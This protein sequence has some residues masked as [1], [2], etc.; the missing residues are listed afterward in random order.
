MSLLTAK[1]G[2]RGQG[3]GEDE[4]RRDSVRLRAAAVDHRS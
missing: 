1:A 2:G 4:H 3:E